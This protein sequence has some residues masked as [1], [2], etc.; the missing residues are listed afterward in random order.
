LA[1]DAA[2]KVVT[3]LYDGSLSK[4]PPADTYINMMRHNVTQM[5]SAL[6]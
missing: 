1:K 2:V 3:D 4:G 5:V 6:K